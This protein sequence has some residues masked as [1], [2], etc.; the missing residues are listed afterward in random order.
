MNEPRLIIFDADGTLRRCTVPGQPCPNRDG[1]WELM[2]GVR[3]RIAVLPATVHFGIVSNQGGVGLGLMSDADASRMLIE[4]ADQALGRGRAAVSF[5]PHAP[6]ADCLCRKPHPLMLYNVMGML[7][8]RPSETLYVGDMVSDKEAAQ[9][10][11]VAFAWAWE[12]FGWPRPAETMAPSYQGQRD[13][14]HP[15]PMR[16]PYSPRA[17]AEAS[18][19]SNAA[20][21]YV[22]PSGPLARRRHPTCDEMDRDLAQIEKELADEAA[23]KG[24]PA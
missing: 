5:C 1:E 16:R 19:T 18:G 17:E 11:G 24:Q 15:D 3:E 22:N 12:F 8:V 10:A 21:A 4:L 7:D 20:N 13:P 9:R 14:N 2:P 23:G 6:K